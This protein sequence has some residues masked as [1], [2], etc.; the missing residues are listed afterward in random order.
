MSTWLIWLLLYVFGPFRYTIPLNLFVFLFIAICIVSFCVGDSVASHLVSRRTNKSNALF[1]AIESLNDPL[2]FYK[3]KVR[4]SNFL[5]YI[6]FVGFLGGIFFIIVKLFF[7]GLDYSQGVSAA[8]FQSQVTDFQGGASVSIIAYLSYVLFPFSIVAFLASF[9]TDSLSRKAK[10]LSRLSFLIP[11]IV[12]VLTGGRGTILHTLLL[13]LS[14]PLAGRKNRNIFNAYQLF[15]RKISNKLSLKKVFKILFVL[16]IIILFLYYWM[17]IYVD[18]RNLN[19]NNDALVYL[20]YAKSTYGIY[21]GKLLENLMARGL[22]SPELVLNMMQ[23]FYYFTHGPLVF[24]KMIDSQVSVG[25]YFGQYQV[26]LLMT[27]SRIF[28]PDLS[29]ST[30]VILELKQA[31]TY[32]SFPSA[33]GSFFLDFGWIGALIEAFLLG[34]MCK[35]IYIF[36]VSKDQLGDKLF[37]LFV[38]TSIY[39]SPAVPP[40]GIS[41]N[42]FVFVAFLF[43]RNPLNKLNKKVS[44]FKDTVRA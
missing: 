20:D 11:V 33:W 38:M 24:S 9:L 6:V 23:S 43:T 42:A 3:A 16:M 41:L 34:C 44:L 4:L 40:L 35:I 7:S 25:P 21:P 28:L 29:V 5:I 1:S 37:L 18:R 19:A 14:L 22:I 31:G 8:R 17:Y 39:I 32:G 36:A 10:I 27:L 26:P 30:Q 2:Y 12:N 15:L 13:A